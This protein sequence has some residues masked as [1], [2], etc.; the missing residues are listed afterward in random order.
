MKP[1]GNINMATKTNEEIIKKV[2]KKAIKN[3]WTLYDEKP[4][5]SMINLGSKAIFNFGSIFF[6][7]SKKNMEVAG[8]LYVIISSHKFAKYFWG[9]EDVC[10]DCGDTYQ[11][12]RIDL[13]TDCGYEGDGN[14]QISWQYHLQQ[15]VLEED[16]IKYLEKF[17]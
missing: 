15:M 5:I 16:P 11:K 2:F 12:C 3:G 8:D 14:V 4:E 10:K 1:S 17:L 9:I 7:L 13:D 6:D